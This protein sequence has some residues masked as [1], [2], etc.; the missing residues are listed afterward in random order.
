[1]AWFITESLDEFVAGADRFLRSDPTGNTLPLTIVQT[2]RASGLTAYGDVPLFGWWR[3]ADGTVDGAFLQTPPYPMLLTRMPAA[4]VPSLVDELTAAGRRLPG[5]N[6][7][8]ETAEDFA[9]EWLRRTGGTSRVHHQHRLYRLGELVPPLPAPP[10][11]ARVATAADR[12]LVLAWWEAFV[13]EADDPPADRSG[14]V[15]DRI[16]Y[17][18]LTLW[19]VDGVAVSMA[20]ISRRVAGVARVGPVYTPPELRRRGYAAAA[21]AVVSRVALDDGAT[22]VL[23][24]AD[25]ANSTSNALY[26]RLGYRPVDDVVILSFVEETAPVERPQRARIL[27]TQA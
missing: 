1:M 12:D 4:A 14:V 8:R 5:I 13:R 3:A 18:G 21:T 26:E 15:D 10:G 23:L 11:A 9:T 17:G 25:L 7:G 6:A 16:G 27:D 20:G 22:E 2:L 24:F 19:E